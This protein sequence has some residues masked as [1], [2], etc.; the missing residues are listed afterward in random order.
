LDLLPLMFCLKFWLWIQSN[1]CRAAG[2]ADWLPRCRIGVAS[3]WT[4]ID[5]NGATHNAW[6]VESL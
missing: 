5:W 3:V 6:I 4:R 2:H 1:F